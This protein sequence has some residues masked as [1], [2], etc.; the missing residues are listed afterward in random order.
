MIITAAGA[1]MALRPATSDTADM[2]DTVDMADMA[3]TEETTTTGRKPPAPVGL[4]L[5]GLGMLLAL[6]RLFQ[7]DDDSAT[8]LAR[9]TP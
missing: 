8:L 2:A 1:G 7:S 9:F 6:L 4:Y 5:F 3:D